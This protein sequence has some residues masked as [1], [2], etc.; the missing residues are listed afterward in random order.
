MRD[1]DDEDVITWDE[2]LISQELLSRHC[3]EFIV[4]IGSCNDQ[5]QS[6]IQLRRAII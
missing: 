6:N 5:H 1:D 2:E 3:I 4:T